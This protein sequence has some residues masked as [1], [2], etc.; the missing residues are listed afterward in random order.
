MK[1]ILHDAG[2]PSVGIFPYYNTVEVTREHEP[3]F[4]EDEVE[5]LKDGLRDA[6]CPDGVCVTEAE[7]LEQAARDGKAEEDLLKGQEEEPA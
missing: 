7:F 4:T 6:L 3:Q 2:D 1:F 5:A